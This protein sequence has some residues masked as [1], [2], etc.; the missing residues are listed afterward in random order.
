M[1]WKRPA[2]EEKYIILLKPDISHSKNKAVVKCSN[3]AAYN[4]FL[5]ILKFFPSLV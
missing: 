2:M 1:A 5:L 3:F 4:G